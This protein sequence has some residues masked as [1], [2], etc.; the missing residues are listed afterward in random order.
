[1][2]L[3]ILL[4][5]YLF[6]CMTG[7]YREPEIKCFRLI[8]FTASATYNCDVNPT[9]DDLST[10]VFGCESLGLSCIIIAKAIGNLPKN[11]TYI[12]KNAL[13]KLLSLG[14]QMSYCR[15]QNL[16]S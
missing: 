8:P 3:S 1:M 9:I 7:H 6:A 13:E 5:K 4:P 15:C 2:I 10:A 16:W 12:S 14:Q 11:I